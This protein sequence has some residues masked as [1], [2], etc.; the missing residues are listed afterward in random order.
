[1]AAIAF[2]TLPGKAVAASGEVSLDS[3]GHHPR[4]Q[5]AEGSSSRER[6]ADFD[7]V[8]PAMQL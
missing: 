5:V 4:I 6:R 3:L 7:R 8:Y 1:M 2:R